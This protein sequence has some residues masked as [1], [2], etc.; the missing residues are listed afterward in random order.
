MLYAMVMLRFNQIL[1]VFLLLLLA[2]CTVHFKSKE[3]EL[4]T[5]PVEP[6]LKMSNH[7]YE[8]EKIALLER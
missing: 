6:G 3:L 2:G 4:E 7:T 5:K 8:L 1:V